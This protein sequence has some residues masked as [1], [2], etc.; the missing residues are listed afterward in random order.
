M[1]V[2]ELLRVAAQN[3]PT[4]VATVWGDQEQSYAELNR[5]CEALASALCDGGLEQG[6]RVGVLAWNR[7]EVIESYFATWIAGGCVVPLNA[8]F[9]VDEVVQQLEHCT[10]SAVIL[11]PEHVEMAPQLLARLENLEQ[12]YAIE[13]GVDGAEPYEGVIKLGRELPP[14]QREVGPD[15]LAWLFFT[16][17]TTGRPKGAML[18][19]HNLAAMATTWVQ[20]LTPLGPDDVGM[21]AAPLSHGAGFHAIALTMAACPQVIVPA[22]PFSPSILSQLV[23]RH[24]VTNTWMVP[25]QIIALLD[26]PGADLSQLE[27]LQRI[28]YG[29]A[30]M[31]AA[32]LE[33]GLAT[34]GQVFVQLYGQGETPMTATFLAPGEHVSG[35]PLLTSCGRARTRTEIAILDA[36]NNELGRGEIGEICVR[37]P[38][39]MKGYWNDPAATRE[40][41]RDGW[42]HTGDLGCMDEAGYVFIKDRAK[43]MIIS[44]GANVYPREVEE[45][46]LAHPAVAQACV[47][48]V[49]D[50]KWGE[51]VKAVVVLA[52]GHDGYAEEL[53]EYVGTRIAG[54]KK[55]RSIEFAESLPK[56]AYGK[57]LKRELRARYWTDRDRLV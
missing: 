33:R 8:R 46:L 18:T 45:V 22:R 32:D 1:N 17:G 41:V 9:L 19:H 53:I 27:S 20:D 29:G 43:D 44:G 16:S 39:V 10:A 35:S 48:G 7:P 30:P 50:G 52:P 42:L 13:R 28:V 23:A 40:A 4:G 56:S 51:S 14:A 11:G 15:D 26:D 54:Y 21:H 55:P 36:D 2:A 34:L 6:G 5:R 12:V 47:F 3:R 49:P 37:G 31:Y 25:T 24:R 38:T 57:T